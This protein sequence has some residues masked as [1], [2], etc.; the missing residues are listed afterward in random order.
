MRVPTRR[1][2]ILA[3]SKKVN[4]AFLTPAA[5]QRMKDEVVRLEKVERP[6]A[7][8]ELRRTAAMGDLSE[9]AAYSYAKGELRR[10]NNR[11]EWLK[12]RIANAIPIPGASVDGL[13]ALGSTVVVEFAGKRQT[14][15]IVGAQETNPMRGRISYLSPIG[16]SLIGHAAGDVVGAYKIIEVR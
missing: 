8:E 9:N 14:F 5:I 3:Q 16:S 1:G 11:I 10:I 2:E 7:A 6:P 12:L 13:V 15:E 4:D